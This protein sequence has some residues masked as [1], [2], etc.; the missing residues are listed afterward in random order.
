[1]RTRLE[2]LLVG[3]STRSDEAARVVHTAHKK[4]LEMA[5]KKQEGTAMVVSKDDTNVASF[6]QKAIETKAPVETL[7]RLFALQKEVNAEHAKSAFVE[8]L[9]AFQGECPVIEKKKRVLNKD[10]RTVRYHYA[11]IDSIAQQIKEPLAK[12]HLSYSWDVE[13]KDKHMIVTCKLTHRDGH[14]ETSTFEIPIVESEG[15]MTMP[16][17]YASAQTYAKRYT[18]LNVLGIATADEDTDATDVEKEDDV[19]SEKSKV[20][21][22]LRTLGHD[23]DTKVKITKA[24]KTLTNLALNDKN[25][26]EIVS[27]LEILVKEKQEYE[28]SDIQV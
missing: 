26:G 13:H 8:A 24:V 25:L 20:I 4:Q 27:R 11:P 22:L 28:N 17:K 3:G 16:Q 15:Y 19:K 7:E 10:G 23:T 2:V 1:M 21:F 18:L 5:K 6:I 12:N 14:H 9:T